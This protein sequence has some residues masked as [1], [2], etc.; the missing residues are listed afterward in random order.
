MTLSTSETWALVHAERQRLLDDLGPLAA[1]RWETPS[2]CRGWTVHE[3]L[4]HLL[5]TAKTGRLAFVW[6]MV[7]ARGDFDRANEDGVRRCKRDDPRQTLAEFRDVLELTRTAPANRATRLVEAIVHGE[8][9]RR[10]LEIPADYP[11]AG[12]HEALAYQL[13][14]PGSFGGARDRAEGCRLV[15]TDTG[16]SWGD[17][18]DVTG[19]AVDLLL[20][21][22]GREIAPG[23]LVGPGAHRLSRESGATPSSDDE[24]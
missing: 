3:V 12:L 23:L 17:G 11:S 13:R 15:D 16:A 1:H 24:R 8:D 20:A 4:A 9:I 19:R 22:S 6:S 7:R 14:T 10:P 2:L 5:D 21:A 18:L